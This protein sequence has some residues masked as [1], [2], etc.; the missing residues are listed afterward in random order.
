MYVNKTFL[1]KTGLLP[2]YLGKICVKLLSAFLNLTVAL[3]L[4]VKL[5]REDGGA[6]SER[7]LQL[8]GI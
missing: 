8:N 5:E 6:L 7:G 1:M 4:Q 2:F 3:T